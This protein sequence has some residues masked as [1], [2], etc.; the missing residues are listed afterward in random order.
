MAIGSV[1]FAKLGRSVCPQIARIDPDGVAR[2]LASWVG[3]NLTVLLVILLQ[4]GLE[5]PAFVGRN[6]M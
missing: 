2:R 5:H 1:R 4:R 3:F 6:Q